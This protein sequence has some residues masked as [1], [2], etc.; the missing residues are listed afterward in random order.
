[1]PAPYLKRDKSTGVY[2]VHWTEPGG[3]GKRVSTRQNDLAAAQRFFAEW[4]LLKDAS[5]V[6]EP[7][8]GALWAAYMKRHDFAA[9][10]LAA[11]YWRNSLEASFALLAPSQVTQAVVDRYVDARPVK[12]QTA[13]RELRQLLACLSFHNRK[14][15]ERLRLPGDGAPRDRWLTDAEV[16]KMHAAAADLAGEKLSR[17][18]VFLWL[19]LETAARLAAILEL[20]WD[21]VD[22]QTNVIHYDWAERKKTKK[23]RASVPISASLRPVLERAFQERTNEYVV[24]RSGDHMWAQVQRCVRRAGLAPPTRRGVDT[25]TGISPHVFRHTAATKMARSGVPLWTIAKVLGN[26][27]GMVEKVYSHHAPDDLRE[28]VNLISRSGV[29]REKLPDSGAVVDRMLHN[30]VQQAAE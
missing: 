28:A 6:D 20:T 1:M 3:R 24:P 27:V 18:Q 15:A 10:D 29:G 19:A 26:T 8:I 21:R 4:I 17:L 13:A 12:P 30:I 9:R 14:P 11:R 7:L 22:L 16:A 23:R 25:A 5:P 2:S